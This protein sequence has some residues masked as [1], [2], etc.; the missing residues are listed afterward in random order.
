MSTI[1]PKDRLRP[2]GAPTPAVQPLYADR[3]KVYPKAVAGPVRRAKW[4]VLALCLAAY[5]I[6]PWLRWDRGPGAADQAV[7]VDI[8]NG[9]LFFFFIEIW[10]QEVYFLTGLLVLGAIGLFVATSLF[11]RVWCGFACPQT[12]WTDLFMWV[13][14]QIQGDRNER[15]RLDKAP[16][17]PSKIRKKVL[18]HAAWLLIAAATGG[19]WIMYFND[20]PTVTWEVLTG[21]ASLEVYFF[22]A[23]FSGTTYLLAGWA[24]E[25]VCT[26]M[27]PWPRFQAAML[28]ENSLV[29]T[30]RE[31]RGEP[32]G[33]WKE[34]GIGDCVDC[35][36][37]VNVCPTG[38]DIRDGQQLECIGCGLCIDACDDIMT[39]LE[40]PKGLVAFETLANLAASTAAAKAV[41]PGAPRLAA[42]MAARRVP[43]FIRPRTVLYAALLGAVA[44]VMLGAFLLREAVTLSVLRDRAPLFVTLS[45]GSIRN[46][47]TLKIANKGREVTTLVLEIVAPQALHMQVQEG[48]V[49]DGNRFA[50]TTRPDGITQWRVLVTQPD[51]SPRHESID[52]T[53]RLHDSDGRIAASAHSVFLGPKP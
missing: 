49:M 31:W 38:I 17:S 24:R 42:G 29:V 18:T 48:Q 2:A 51:S 20:A 39:R 25:Q 32:R 45:D 27:C 43:R 8:A 26:Y 35:R 10:P 15:M 52:I 28:D 30:Y 33:K 4:V 36:A 3:Q 13:E 23:L 47:Y 41:P 19:A 16:W 44:A 22:F 5:Y 53:F 50:V 6:V 7:L 11:G 40:R 37:C 14:R 46:G 34:E 1:Q 9:R 21:R 12:V